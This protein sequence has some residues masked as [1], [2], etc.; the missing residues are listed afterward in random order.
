MNN[1]SS[2]LNSSRSLI[3]L[4]SMGVLMGLLM[5]F[6]SNCFVLGVEWFTS[7]REHA[8]L[9]GISFFGL[10]VSFAAPIFLLS[11]AGLVLLIKRVFGI[12]R[13]HGP[14]DS[15][16]AAH[17]STNDLDLKT[18][19]GSTLAA[20]VSASGG[21]SVGQYGPLVHFGTAVG[22]LIQRYGGGRVSND[23]F[24][25]CGVAGAI[26]A[27]FNAPLAGILF[28]HEVILR[29]LSL[30]AMAPIAM[31]SIVAAASS[32]WAIGDR[33]LFELKFPSL[34]LLDLLPGIL[35]TTPVFAL[36]AILFMLVML[37]TA[38]FGAETRIQPAYLIV[39]ASLVCGTTGM[40]F[41]EVLGLGTDTIDNMISG[42]FSV[43]Y[44]C[45]LL[46]AKALMTAICVGFGLFGGVV[47]PALFIGTAAGVL[48]SH[49]ISIIGLASGSAIGVAGMAAVAAA[50]IGAP[51][52]TI[53]LLL[54]ITKSY[55]FAVSAMLAVVTCT[56]ITNEFFGSSLFDRQ[57]RDRGINLERVR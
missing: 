16:H 4:L 23:I 28:A 25:G 9:R 14:A 8:G 19:F 7:Q 44:L 45:I 3:F 10:N 37:R 47:L 49:V 54:E 36:V 1:R 51:L 33:L 27:G 32:R 20:F 52:S 43:A 22:C 42:E 15:I 5:A 50:V 18:G 24:I 48:G 53:I 6:V 38:R 57:L 21:A 2:L 46:V 17:V 34:S 39:I 12:E 13:Y 41:P 35:L 29:R 56:L 31:S 30:R 26:S 40:F 55:E 11:A